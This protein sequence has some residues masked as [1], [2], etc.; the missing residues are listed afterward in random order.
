MAGLDTQPNPPYVADMPL[1]ITDPDGIDAELRA[2]IDQYSLHTILH[3]LVTVSYDRADIETRQRAET[4]AWNW[5]FIAH[6]LA[7]VEDYASRLTL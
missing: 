1:P 7:K 5:R 6:L 2:L 3:R 4:Q